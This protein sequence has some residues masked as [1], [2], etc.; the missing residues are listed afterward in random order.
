MGIVLSM[1]SQNR[2]RLY[3][4]GALWA[5]NV[6]ISQMKHHIA[7]CWLQI[8]RCACIYNIA[9]NWYIFTST[10][11]IATPFVLPQISFFVLI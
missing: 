8:T 9:Y 7:F 6:I 1:A 4:N 2:T 10:L 11:S 5:F 3:S